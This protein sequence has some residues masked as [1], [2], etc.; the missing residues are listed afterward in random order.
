MAYEGE[1][2][3]HDPV[4]ARLLRGL[5][6]A[7]SAVALALAATS[8]ALI[9][10]TPQIDFLEGWGFRG[11][12]AAFTVVFVA[13]GLLV[14]VRRPENVIG[15]LFLASGLISAV[16]TAADSYAE[17]AV[18]SGAPGGPEAFWFAGWIWLPALALIA[19]TL[20]LFPT[21]RPPSPRWWVIVLAM[22]PATFVVTL[23]WAIAQ[24]PDVGA[25]AVRTSLNAV[26]PLGL[27][28][29]HP[30][31][32]VAGMSTVLLAAG[33][34]AAA[35]SLGARMRL[36]DATERQQ[37]KWVLYAGALVGPAFASSVLTTLIVADPAIAKATQ[38]LGISAVL[39]VPIAAAIAILRYRLYDIDV[40]INRTLVYG[41]VSAILG[42]AYVLGVI[43]FQSLLR[44]F[45]A[46]NELAIAVST[47]IVAAL[48]QPVRARVQN[49]VDRRFYRARYDAARTLDEFSDRL[50][51]DVDLDSVRSDLVS[52]LEETVRPSHATVWLRQTER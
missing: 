9:A 25:E 16:Q 30:L 33:V 43:L 29:D 48:F 39:L 24:P 35:V 46:G 17:Y 32:T 8:V 22:V 40:L 28:A 11:Y 3:G 49:A 15:W 19:V 20:M 41:G 50:R 2:V 10:T 37:I 13:V 6:V 14:T 4:N 23:L 38:L 45:T 51:G 44:P 34:V 31:R 21:G 47:L 42:A 7:S 5:A 26:D 12:D 18:L 27:G 1:G 52:V 36:S